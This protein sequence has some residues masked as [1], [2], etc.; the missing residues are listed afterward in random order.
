[1]PAGR[2]DVL[3]LAHRVPY[4][5]DKGDRIR[6]YQLL[7][8]LSRRATV[9]LACLAD[10]PVDASVREVLARTA[11]RVEFV[12]V[13][14]SRWARALAS[15]ALGG[16]ASEGAFASRALANVLTGW[17]RETCFHAA[18]A[19]ASSLV[20]YLRLPALRR[21]PA[22]V[23][24]VD[25]DSQKWLDYAAASGWPRSWL[26]RLEGRRLR[27][28]E[29]GLPNWTHGVLLSSETE[30]ALYRRFAA[31]GQVVALNNGVDLDY[32]RPLP[33]AAE[34]R[35]VFVGALDYRPN[36]DAVCW[37]C[38]EAWPEI[39]RRRPEATLALVGRQPTAAVSAL[40]AIDGVEVVG[41]VPDVR[42]HVGRA[43][44]VVAPLRIARGVQNK[45]L[46][47]LAMAK[48][49]VASP[50]A[51]CG[52]R[53]QPDRHLLAATTPA[54]WVAAVTRLFDDADLRARL[55]GA[56]RRYVE[57]QHRWERCLEPLSDVLGLPDADGD[58]PAGCASGPERAVEP[59]AYK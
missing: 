57:E 56:G 21:T 55:G 4:P 22:V 13:G 23:D 53:A 25:V 24:L 9:H 20:P 15:L 29:Q 39:R 16:T 48:A 40:G 51:L 41:Q 19:S 46:E 34:P 1:M 7:R 8:W 30:K 44:V 3:F 6:S 43:A 45:V 12:P 26:Y 17:G 14:R 36:V 59:A 50:A 49:T 37:F 58:G 28:V 5:P 35:C 11:A 32:F 31:G 33:P 52:V 2:P 10:E 18:V 47:A 38:E 54:E 42:P 27:R